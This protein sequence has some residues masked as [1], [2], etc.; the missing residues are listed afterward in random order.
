LPLCI[1]IALFALMLA[2]WRK[3]P[4]LSFALA[5]A[6]LHLIPLYLF[7]PRLDIANERQM[8]LA[9]W[10]LFLAISIEL[11]LWLNFRALRV[12]AAALLFVLASLTI[13]RNQVYANE[14]S[15]WQDTVLKSPDKA[16]VHNNL[17]HA[18]L[19]AQRYGEARREFATA[20]QLDPQLYQA[21][22]NLFRADDEMEKAGAT[23]QP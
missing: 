21:R 12:V 20:L 16:R 13:S 15:L 8:Y 3:R 23:L 11:T 2:F 1:S 4:W 6:M 18:Y 9:G 14:I 5:W 10:P 17:G 19:L 7:L 22:Y